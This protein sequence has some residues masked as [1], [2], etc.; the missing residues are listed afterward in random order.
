MCRK[1]EKVIRFRSILSSPVLETPGKRERK[2]CGAS[3]IRRVVSEE[4]VLPAAVY[5]YGASYLPCRSF[6]RKKGVT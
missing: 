5:T 1:R 4:R 2:S 3:I 6:F